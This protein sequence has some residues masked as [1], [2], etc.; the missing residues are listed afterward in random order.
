MCSNF[1]VFNH[2]SK[3]IPLH[4]EVLALCFL[5]LTIFHVVLQKTVIPEKT[6][7]QEVRKYWVKNVVSVFFIG[8]I[9]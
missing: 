4:I 2:R 5:T 9:G 7:I 3:L 8:F 6:I 1:L